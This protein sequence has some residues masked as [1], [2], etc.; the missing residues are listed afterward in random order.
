MKSLRPTDDLA[1]DHNL[2]EPVSTDLLIRQWRDKLLF[3]LLRLFS[4]VALAIL[5]LDGL[6]AVTNAGSSDLIQ[7]LILVGSVLLLALMPRLDYAMRLALTLA[8]LGGTAV[9]YLIQTG[10]I[11]IGRIALFALV[12]AGA[13]LLHRRGALWIWV[14]SIGVQGV[15]FAGLA[16]GTVQMLPLALERATDPFTL[17]TNW[18][19]QA[20]ISGI[21]A[22]MIVIGVA[23]LQESLMQE[24]RARMDLLRLNIQLEQ[25]VAERTAELQAE[26]AEH[27]HA[28]Q[29]L[30]A[31]E[32]RFR[33]MFE[34][35]QAVKLL[36]DPHTGMIVDA[37]PAACRYY[38]Y[39]CDQLK[40]MQISDINTLPPE[41]IRQEMECARNEQR[42]Y[43][44][45][46]HRLASGEIRDV[47]VHSSP[48][49]LDGRLI[50]Y[51]II[52]DI[53]R[54]V[55]TERALHRANAQ[56]QQQ[57]TRDALTGLYNRRHLDATLPREL[58]QAGSFHQPVGI[59]MLDIDHFKHYNDT[60]GHDAGDRLLRQLGDFL[61]RQIRAKQ[62]IACRYG[63]EEFILILPGATL[64]DALHRA[65]QI[66]SAVSQF[67]L[68]YNGIQLKPITLS[69]G[70]AVYPQ[71]GDDADT[72]LKAADSALYA[73]KRSGRNRVV[74]A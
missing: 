35:N 20:A 41:Q 56:L 16:T 21:F 67:E 45:F 28:L 33:T 8:L 10:M 68:E 64:C 36:I 52:H 59:V 5:V 11:G 47:E 23:R 55:E 31:S 48:L 19:Y 69:L 50:L 44:V 46:Q 32:A 25:R 14:F 65:E 54:R 7:T 61:M 26:I 70:V 66:R 12:I 30:R 72:L 53:T 62:D 3:S 39:G 15:I 37:N 58:A 71:H 29:A 18:L 1:H 74:G 22:L 13:V 34:R 4:V 40:A 24:Q 17:A 6:A 38:G 27:A 63:G 49:E 57:A 73:A 9:I 60:Y 51:S 43:F 42:N 2:A